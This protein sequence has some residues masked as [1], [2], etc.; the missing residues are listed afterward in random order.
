M[1]KDKTEKKIYYNRKGQIDQIFRLFVG[2]KK[3][4]SIKSI[5]NRDAHNVSKY[6]TTKELEKLESKDEN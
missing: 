3:K 2:F 5:I 1:D 6:S 4:T